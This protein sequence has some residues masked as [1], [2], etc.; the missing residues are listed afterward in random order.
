MV[1]A[2]SACYLSGPG[3]S[4]LLSF[5]SCLL[6]PFPFL[7][8]AAPI[9]YLSGPGYTFL[10]LSVMSWPSFTYLVISNVF[11]ITCLFQSVVICLVLAY[12]RQLP[13]APCPSSSLL[14][15]LFPCMTTFAR[16]LSKTGC[17][18]NLPVS[19]CSL[20]PPVTLPRCYFLLVGCTF[21]VCLL[22][23]ITCPVLS[24]PFS[25]PT[26]C[27]FCYLLCSVKS[28]SSRAC[29]VLSLAFLLL[30]EDRI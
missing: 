7:V 5:L 24:F 19:S 30:K 21:P 26:D 28:A 11:P 10:V 27:P 13:S 3:C 2:T 16:Y 17:P 15:L 22:P 18:L 8:L 6:M 23:V 1:L 25:Y 14:L 12:P 4:Y 20:P 29:L 9:C